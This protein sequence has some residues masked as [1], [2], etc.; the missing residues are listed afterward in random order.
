MGNSLAFREQMALAGSAVCGFVNLHT[1]DPGI[2][3]A[4]EAAS[5]RGAITWSGG[6]VDGTVLGAELLLNLPAGTYTHASLFSGASGANFQTSYLLS[7]S[8]VL[9]VAGAVRVI[10][11]FVY[12]A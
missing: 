12:P 5:P 11:Q 1:G 8:V 4:L 3:G 9:T 10:P 2:T 7:T 6:A